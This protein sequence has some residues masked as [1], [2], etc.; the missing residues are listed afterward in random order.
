VATNVIH[1]HDLAGG[2]TSS[3]I[4]TTLDA[5][6][7]GGMWACVV[8]TAQ[9]TDVGITPL[10][11]TTATQHF[12][13]A[14]PSHWTGQNGTQFVP[15]VAV[16]VKLSTGDRGRSKRG[17]IFLPFV[18]ESSI[19]NG[20]LDATQA[21]AMQTEWNDFQDDLGASAVS[22]LLVVASYKL[23]SQTTAVEPIQVET[24]LGTQRR[25]QGRLR[26]A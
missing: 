3:D 24:V 26:G 1:I 11:G 9:V 4:M 25:R 12:T 2:H 18:A 8:P 7:S 16:V 15:Q 21:A 14:T 10:D 19:D 17:R 20:F 23:A 6:A 22:C 5:A 13:P